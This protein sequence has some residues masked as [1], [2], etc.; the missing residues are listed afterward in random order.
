[1]RILLA[2]NA[3]YRPPRGGATRSNLVWLDHLARA[4]HQCR[5]VAAASQEGAE[6]PFH[7]SIA[8]AAIAQPAARVEALQHE[9]REFAPDWVLVSSEDLGHALLR[10]ARH[11]APGRVVY[12]AH[13]PQFFPFGRESWSPDRHAAQA[14]AGAA[15]IVTIGAHMAGYVAA[16]SGRTAAVIHPPIYGAGPFPTCAS[17]DRG[18]VTM[19]NPCAVKGI[20][21]FAAT[22]RRLPRCQFGAVPGW[23]TSAQDR[24]LLDPLP[25][26]RFLPNARRI[27]D[28]LSQT[29][30]LLMPS[31]WYEGFGLIVM[32]AML[33]GIPVI[34]SDSG[35]LRE[36]KCGTGYVIPVQPIERYQPVFDEH[37]MPRPVQP[38]NDVAPWVDAV[39]ELTGRRDAWERASEAARAAATAFVGGLNAG[40]LEAWLTA[41]R[42]ADP[43]AGEAAQE[44]ATMESLSPEK[45]ELLLRRL[46]RRKICT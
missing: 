38:A 31:L 17:F 42:P 37:G 20:S 30:V 34:A 21:L 44:A 36:A 7:P 16:E 32:E 46:H 2:A 23:G 11:I 15:G 22:A 9:I 4:G 29:R 43:P 45:R 40:D 24:R 6:L 26:V 25:N 35:G 19:V 1:M 10:E 5:I 12:L 18:L 8:L 14:V 41:L 3:S 13:T 39:A 33:R 27:D 28:I